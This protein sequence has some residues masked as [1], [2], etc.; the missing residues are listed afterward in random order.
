LVRDVRGEDFDRNVALQTCVPG[1]IDFTHSPAA[2]GLQDFIRT[3]MG[4]AC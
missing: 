4:A 1:A 2:N 3:E